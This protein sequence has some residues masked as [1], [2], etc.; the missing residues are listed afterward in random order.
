MRAD[1]YTAREISVRHIDPANPPNGLPPNL[2]FPQLQQAQSGGMRASP[3]TQSMSSLSARKGFFSAI[4][5]RG[6]GK[7]ERESSILGPP[8]QRRDIRGLA[9][10]TPQGDVSRSSLMP[11]SLPTPRAQ[12]AAPTP[13]GPRGPRTS[14]ASETIPT[15]SGP[16]R[17]FNPANDYAGRGSLDASLARMGSSRSSFDSSTSRKLSTPITGSP[18]ANEDD[19]KQMADVL[20]HVEQAVLRRYLARYRGQMEAIG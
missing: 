6:S 3:S 13:Q 11:G 16:Q 19:I 18:L 14:N 2:P 5:R 10:S 9:I 8:Q 15:T 7:K 12:S 4:G 20:P 1:S 17:H